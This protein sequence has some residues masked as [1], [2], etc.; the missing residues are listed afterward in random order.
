MRNVLA[1]VLANTATLIA[2]LGKHTHDATIKD[3]TGTSRQRAAEH[4]PAALSDFAEWLL[5]AGECS[6]LSTPHLLALYSEFAMYCGRRPLSRC[7]LFRGLR[8]AG[9]DRKREGADRRRW[10]YYVRSRNAETDASLAG[11]AVR[12]GRDP[13]RVLRHSARRKS[14]QRSAEVDRRETV[15]KGR[16]D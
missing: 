16:I 3:G 14:P 8:A 12:N 11:K 10:L 9:I 1:R 13:S 5:A 6:R 2:S 7:C 15:S 4:S